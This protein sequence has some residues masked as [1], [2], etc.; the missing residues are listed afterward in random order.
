MGKEERLLAYEAAA[1]L[2]EGFDA[3]LALSLLEK[4]QITPLESE[5]IIFIRSLR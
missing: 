2:L 4:I 1:K 3:D 5:V